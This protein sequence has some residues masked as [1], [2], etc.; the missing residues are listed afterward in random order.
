MCAQIVTQAVPL[1]QVSL[2]ICRFMDASGNGWVSDAIRC[3]EYCISKG[4]HVMSNSWGG[5]EYSDSLQVLS[6]PPDSPL[7]PLQFQHSPEPLPGSFEEHAMLLS[8]TA[9]ERQPQ[10]IMLT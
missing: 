10:P 1:Q 3:I 4:A 7:T 6:D 9:A 5:V 2:V 8:S